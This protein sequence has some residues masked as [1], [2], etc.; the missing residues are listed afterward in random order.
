MT[1]F[2]TLLAAGAAL[3]A[4]PALAH[5]GVH[6]HDPY[7]RAQGGNGGSGAVYLMIE[8]HATVDD[9][10]LSV[11]STIAEVVQLHSNVT[12]AEGVTHMNA[13]EDGLEIPAGQTIALMR[14][15]NHIMLMGLTRSLQDGDSFD[16]TL[17]FAHAGE[18]TVEVPVDNARKPDSMGAMGH[19]AMEPAASN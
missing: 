10:L 4:L 6:I 3:F 1:R 13:M 16:L 14:G 5:D 18:V 2:Q 11:S 15:D 12:D 7:A 9:T 8:N 19:D 17:T